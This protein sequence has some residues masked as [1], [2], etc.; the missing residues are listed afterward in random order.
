MNT[1][2]TLDDVRED[3]REVDGL[4]AAT[5][6]GIANAIGN[7][8]AMAGARVAI[9]AILYPDDDEMHAN[10]SA[11]HWDILDGYILT[12]LAD[13]IGY[14]DG[15]VYAEPGYNAPDNGVLAVGY[16]SPGNH[17]DD[18]MRERIQV[19]IDALTAMGCHVEY[20]D[21]WAQCGNCDRYVRTQPDSYSWRPFYSWGDGEVTCG[22]CL[23]REL[24]NLD[25][26]DAWTDAGN[27]GIINNPRAAVTWTDA[28]GMVRA[29]WVQYIP[30]DDGRQAG[31]YVTGW[32]PGQDDNPGKVYDAIRARW[33]D[34]DDNPDD[35]DT[36][37]RVLF[38]IDRNDQFSTN[39]SAWIWGDDLD[40]DD[41]DELR[42]RGCIGP[43][44]ER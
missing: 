24:G 42:G 12:E 32:H 29:G 39:W 2:R 11:G 4:P 15:N 18:E 23:A 33:S 34:P 3:L 9:A 35:F 16:W 27:D 6:D 21:E 8:G 5:A 36:L 13:G 17:D 30:D 31:E 20:G 37:P 40:D 44:V 1:I 38:L 25:T 19:L 22:D 26:L 41:R 28:A 7:A 14:P 43:I 10:V